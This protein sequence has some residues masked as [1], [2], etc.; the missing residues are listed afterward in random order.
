MQEQRGFN[1]RAPCGARPVFVI[2]STSNLPFQSTRPVRGATRGSSAGHDRRA[3][4]IHAPRAGRDLRPCTECDFVDVSIHAPRAGRDKQ[5]NVSLSVPKG[6]NPRAPCGA[7]RRMEERK[8]I[9]QWFQSTRPVRGATG[10]RRRVSVLLSFQSTR[11]VRGATSCAQQ[12]RFGKSVS[13][14]APRA[15]RDSRRGRI[16]AQKQSFNPRAPCGAR[17][18]I[19]PH[20]PYGPKFQ[21]TRPVRG[22]T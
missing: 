15:G 22:A 3:V 6:F 1:P 14:H 2:S 5:F 19:Y 8:R 10:T 12:F 20:D 16:A 4:S 11:P 13:I 17:H 9:L 21:S 7:R 18:G